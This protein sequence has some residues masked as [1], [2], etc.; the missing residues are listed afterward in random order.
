MYNCF[1]LKVAQSLP[2]LVNPYSGDV[3][4]LSVEVAEYLLHPGG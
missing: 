2:G 1:A 3:D 4:Y